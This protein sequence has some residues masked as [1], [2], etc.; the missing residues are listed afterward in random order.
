MKKFILIFTALF[1]SLS[2][3]NAQTKGIQFT[4]GSFSEILKTAEKEG[5][6]IF[7]DA[8]AT[9]C[10]PCTY[11]A[12]NIFPDEKVGD[13]FNKTF[14]NAKFD[15]EKGEGARLRTQ[16]NV[17]AYP[18]F[19]ILDSDGKELGRLIG[20]APA[21]EFIKKIRTVLETGLAKK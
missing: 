17:T 9:W 16:Y 18:T 7:I 19:L 5:K 14:V 8:Y 6:P 2:A 4:E 10:G 11:M 20:G 1:L 3:S 12:Q 21:E 13:Y 15:M